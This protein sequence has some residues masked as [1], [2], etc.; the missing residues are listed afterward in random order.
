MV[1]QNLHDQGNF[2]YINIIIN[3][4]KKGKSENLPIFEIRKHKQEIEIPKENQK[5]TGCLKLLKILNKWKS[6]YGTI[7][8]PLN[9]LKSEDDATKALILYTDDL[10][11]NTKPENIKVKIF[12]KIIINFFFHFSTFL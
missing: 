5:I 6:P 2:N 1:L 9:Y 8:P 11:E 4:L 7:K 10:D 3:L 12:I